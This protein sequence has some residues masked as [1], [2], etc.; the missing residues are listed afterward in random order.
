MQHRKTRILIKLHP[1]LGWDNEADVG[2]QSGDD[3]L[4]VGTESGDKDGPRI[5][6]GAWVGNLW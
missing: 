5:G 4:D 2:V 3:G 1:R 6:Q